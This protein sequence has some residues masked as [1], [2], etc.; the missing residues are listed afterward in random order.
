MMFFDTATLKKL[1]MKDV[2]SFVDKLLV[3]YRKDD[4]MAIG[5]NLVWNS[6]SNSGN[7]FNKTIITSYAPT[8][9]LLGFAT[10]NNLAAWRMLKE[11]DFIFL[12]K[13][14][15]N[16]RDTISDSEIIKK[17]A[18]TVKE[19]L[20]KL[21]KGKSIPESYLTLEKIEQSCSELF[22]SR[23][24]KIQH[25]SYRDNIY[26]LYDTYDI[27][28]EINNRQSGRFF[29]EFKSIYGIDPICFMRSAVA[30]LAFGSIRLR[31]KFSLNVPS[32]HKDIRENFGIDIDSCKLVA[33]SLSCNEMEI[34]KWYKSVLETDSIYQKH[35]PTPLYKSPIICINKDFKEYII[36]SPFSYFNAIRE[37][38]FSNLI[39]NKIINTDN[40]VGP[41]LEH[42]IETRLKKIFGAN[43]VFKIETNNKNKTSDFI[44]EL[45][46]CSLIFECK[47]TIGS[48]KGSSVMK[49]S[50]VAEMWSRCYEACKQC[51]EIIKRLDNK[52]PIVPIVITGDDIIRSPLS[53]QSF[54]IR[55]EL[56]KDMQMQFVEFI[57]WYELQKILS[58]TSVEKFEK[59]M[60]RRQT[61]IRCTGD[62]INF[63]FESDKPTH[64]YEFTKE[65]EIEILGKNLS[66]L[67]SKTRRQ[68]FFRNK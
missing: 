45:S 42:H 47:I 29:K 48:L 20:I 44:V 39:I 40:D 43:K 64:N 67:S 4:I 10:A 26:G 30:L 19:L 6:F 36:P 31:G 24:I 23:L 52:K 68:I 61:D 32:L 18:L 56:F 15:W 63:N 28:S 65:T 27:M 14:F 21:P 59:E 11:R 33:S 2:Q 50:D 51:S 54:A 58:E 5:V 37:S 57:S 13:E 34:K 62:I 55:S 3:T 16:I 9:I 22:F 17:E 7:S 53:F 41:A 46:L 38:I 66:D 1:Q 8:V 49:P 12:C 60:L 25:C 35:I